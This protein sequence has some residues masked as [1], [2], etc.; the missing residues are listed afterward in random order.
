M[1]HDCVYATAGWGIHD[2]RWVTALLEV[3]LTPHVVSLGRD[4]ADALKLRQVVDAAAAGGLL[5]SPAPSTPSLPTSS[6]CPSSWWAYRGGTTSATSQP[7]MPTS[8]GSP[9]WTA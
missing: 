5:S 9:G 4:D 1:T 2:E 7:R 6:A 3:G 8:P